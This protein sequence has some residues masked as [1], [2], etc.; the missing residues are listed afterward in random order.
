[1]EMSAELKLLR[2]NFSESQADALICRS[3]P[4]GKKC[5]AGWQIFEKSCYFFSSE[6]ANWEDAGELCADQDGHLVIVDSERE[7]VRLE[8]WVGLG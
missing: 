5:S 7:Q 4:D 1:M 8:G 2:S 3:V 6:R